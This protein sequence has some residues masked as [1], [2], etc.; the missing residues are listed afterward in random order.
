M[1]L[2]NKLWDCF[3]S[4]LS[5]YINNTFMTKLMTILGYYVPLFEIFSNLNTEK[6][7]SCGLTTIVFHK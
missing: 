3:S 7:K 4:I 2:D 5:S 1:A 6:L